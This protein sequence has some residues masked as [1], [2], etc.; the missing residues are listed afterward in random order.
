M[1]KLYLFGLVLAIGATPL[2][3]N[4]CKKLVDDATETTETAED[5]S[6]DMAAVSAMIEVIQDVVSTESALQMKSGSSILPDRLQPYVVFTDGDSVFTDG[7]GVQFRLDLGDMASNFEFGD[8]PADL[9][10][11][12]N[13]VAYLGDLII[14]LNK[15]F[16]DPECVIQIEFASR[17]YVQKGNYR[18]IIDDYGNGNNTTS[19]REFVFTRVSNTQWNITYDLAIGKAKKGK[20]ASKKST[21][22]TGNFLLTINDGGQPGML[23]NTIIISGSSTGESNSKKPYTANITEDLESS[24]AP[25]D[26]EIF[27]KGRIELKNKDSKFTILADF[28]DGSCDND[29]EVTLPGNVKKTITIK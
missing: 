6:E 16:N 20:L 12:A 24:P 11:G 4:S 22:T 13:D 18:Y 14:D 9:V 5:F 1:K 15:P 7:D 8:E 21:R 23:D 25:C 28:G 26:A 17:F 29:I 2:L 19:A 3:L 27:T 10:R